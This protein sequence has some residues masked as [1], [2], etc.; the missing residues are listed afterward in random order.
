M[1]RDSLKETC[2]GLKTKTANWKDVIILAIFENQSKFG[3][4]IFRLSLFSLRNVL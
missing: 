1:P 2:F 4:H 3:A